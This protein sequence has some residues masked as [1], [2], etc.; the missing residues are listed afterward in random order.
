MERGKMT[1][2]KTARSRGAVVLLVAGLALALMPDGAQAQQ[3]ALPGAMCAHNSDCPS[4]LQCRLGRCMPQ[5]RENRDCACPGTRCLMKQTEFGPLG[6][7][8]IIPVDVPR[9]IPAACV[10]GIDCDSRRCVGGFCN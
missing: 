5:C 7:C 1:I 2:S 8:E 10:S 3:G 9:R 6:V 4:V